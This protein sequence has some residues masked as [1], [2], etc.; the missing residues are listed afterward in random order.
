MTIYSFQRRMSYQE[1]LSKLSAKG[2]LGGL[3][4]WMSGPLRGV[5]EI[6]L[7]YR[8]YRVTVDDRRLQNLHYY[9]VDAA[10]GTLDPYEFATPPAADAWAEVE[11]RN[12]HPARLN[13]AETEKLVTE[14][15]RRL[16]YSRGFFR[17]VNPNITA[18]LVQSEFYIPYWA[19]FYGDEQNISVTVLNAIRQTVEGSKVRRLIKT[20]LLERDSQRELNLAF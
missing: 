10:A 8:L 5:A 1:A 3:R 20:W 17:L 11:S 19:G 7:P 4:R 18:E 16:L 13:E 9:A 12:F 6:Y 14:K 2:M 15:V